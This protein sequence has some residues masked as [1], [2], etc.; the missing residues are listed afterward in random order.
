[1]GMVVIM[2]QEDLFRFAF[3]APAILLWLRMILEIVLGVA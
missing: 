1:M 3:G 2:S